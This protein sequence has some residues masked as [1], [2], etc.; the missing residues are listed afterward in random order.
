MQSI[1]DWQQSLRRKLPD[2]CSPP[3]PEE[4]RDSRRTRGKSQNRAATPCIPFW[5]A[6]SCLW[7]TQS[8]SSHKPVNNNTFTQQT[9]LLLQVMRRKAIKDNSMFTGSSL[10]SA[11]SAVSAQ[12]RCPASLSLLTQWTLNSAKLETDRSWPYRPSCFPI[13]PP[14]RKMQALPVTAYVSE[15]NCENAEL[16]LDPRRLWAL[17]PA[18]TSWQMHFAAKVWQQQWRNEILGNRE[19]DVAHLNRRLYG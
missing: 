6:Q 17:H 4:D 15:R 11:Q 1:H 13:G 9:T 12:N 19:R 10:E 14:L 16:G 2:C 8:A 18:A 5:I 3:W 7:V